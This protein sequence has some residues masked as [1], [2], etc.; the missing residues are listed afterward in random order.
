LDEFAENISYL[1]SS[2]V[3]LLESDAQQKS[4]IY[5]QFL[6]AS[7][8]DQNTEMHQHDLKHD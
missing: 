5:K 7:F 8:P 6:R 1:I 2:L 3:I 4:P